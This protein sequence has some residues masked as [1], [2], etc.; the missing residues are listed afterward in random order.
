MSQRMHWPTAE[1]VIVDVATAANGR[2]DRRCKN[3]EWPL[4]AIVAEGAMVASTTGLTVTI[5]GLS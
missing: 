1:I 3:C 2:A 4:D 5:I